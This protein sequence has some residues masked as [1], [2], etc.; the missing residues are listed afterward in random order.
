MNWIEVNIFTTSEGVDP[1]CGCLMCIG[2]NGFAIKDS[3]D[4]EDFLERKDGNW[5]YIDDDLMEMRTCETC[6][7]VY[8]A[9]NAQGADIYAALKEQMSSLKARDTENKFGR[10]AIETSGIREED[11][12]N[13]WKQYFKPIEVGGRLLIKPSWETYD[14]NEERIIL[15]IDPESSFGTGQHNTTRLCLELTEKYLKKDIRMLDVGC[16]S[17][18][19]SVAGYLLGA[20]ECTAVDIDSNSV[21]IAGENAE[22]NHIP[23]DKYTTFCGNI[24]GDE[25]LRS[26]ILAGGKFEILTANIVA[27]VLIAMA[28]LFKDF[29]V[30]NGIFIISGIIIERCEEVLAAMRAQGYTQ[31][32]IKEDNGW[33]AAAFS[34]NS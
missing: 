13:N 7:T 25:K 20:M 12:A 16:G 10:L 31:L 32:E 6:V 29:L 24:I 11:W 8:I 30:Q 27:D 21:R 34:V 22:K 33:A 3:K 17:G 1:V 28:P 5:D 19:L 14:K 15:E 18:I 4:F 23:A 26:D 9:D 2:I